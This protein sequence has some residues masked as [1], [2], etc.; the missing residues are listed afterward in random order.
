M[1]KVNTVTKHH[2]IV[3]CMHMHKIPLIV[4]V[5]GGSV[6]LW[7]DV[8]SLRGI[9]GASIYS[10][11]SLNKAVYNFLNDGRNAVTDI[12]DINNSV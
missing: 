6:M 1:Y 3:K 2:I 4:K 11:V 8:S 12:Q 10:E 7:V 5:W 9:I